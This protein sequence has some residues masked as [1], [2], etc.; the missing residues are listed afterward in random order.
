MVVKRIS[1]GF[2]VFIAVVVLLSLVG[3]WAKPASA[4]TCTWIGTTA[5][6]ETISNWSC[7]HIPTSE[8]IVTIPGGTPN[9]PVFSNI[10]VNFQVGSIYIANGAML[11]VINNDGGERNFDANTWQ[12]DGTLKF[13][14][15]SYYYGV[16]MNSS[17][18][19]GVINVT[20]TGDIN[21]D[22][23][24]G[25]LRFYSP[26]NN[27]GLLHQKVGGDCAFLMAAGGEHNGVFNVKNLQINAASQNIYFLANS[28]LNI[29]DLNVT[30]GN[31]YI[32]G[33]YDGSGTL[34]GL[35]IEG[36]TV[37]INSPTVTMPYQTAVG[38]G[39]TLTVNSPLT[40]N[41]LNLTGTLNNN[42]AL[43]VV[44]GMNWSGGGFTGSGYTT[45]ASTATCTLSPLSGGTINHQPLVLDGTCNWSNYSITLS[46]GA[47]ITNNGTF[48][49]NATTTM[50]GGET[51]VFTNNGIFIKNAASTTTT[52]NIPF[53]NQGTVEVVAGSLVF[54]QGME[55][56]EDAV[57][58]LGGGTLD[59]GEELILE[60]GDS[61]VGSGTLAANLV[62]GGTVSPGASPGIITVDG[63][64]ENLN[65]GV[66]QIELGGTEAGTEYDRLDVSGSAA[67][68]GVLNVTLANDF[69]PQPG[70]SFIILTYGSGTGAFSTVNLP[71]G[72]D[73]GYDIEPNRVVLFIWSNGSIGGCVVCN[74]IHTVFVDLY[75]AFPENLQQTVQIS[76]G[77]TFIF[78][79]LAPERYYV[80]AW[81]DLNESGV[82]LPDD[83]E[84]FAW[85]TGGNPFPIELGSGENFEDANILI[86]YEEF[87]IFLPMALK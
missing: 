14:S 3:G 71:E 53:T 18:T 28:E 7:N 52:M 32:Y 4:A 36:G 37:E 66:L 84:P 80:G 45:V 19:T 27:S 62:N 5:N 13:S 56:G 43:D 42:H 40:I 57:I 81:I 77:E 46:D 79:D 6:W 83:F 11:H 58:N 47:W 55:N 65:S 33:S 12:I 15:T 73:W 29:P 9:N 44:S 24:V 20:S 61:L 25:V 87:L 41:V 31:V 69:I 30:G 63:D 50:T 35:I 70:D 22:V 64:Y 59:P 1:A 86:D 21:F 34:S 26:Y 17:V 67:L 8:D 48:N 49:A 51:D 2:K 82:G 74:S 16:S 60:S 75:L 54:Q 39:T 68:D 23:S 85:Y 72:Y 78:P 38:S 10:G 76:C